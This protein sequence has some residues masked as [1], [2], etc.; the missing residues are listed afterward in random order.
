MQEETCTNNTATDEHT[1]ATSDAEQASGPVT[2]NTTENT[3][4]TP[5]SDSGGLEVNSDTAQSGKDKSG[6]HLV[7]IKSN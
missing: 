2:E 7:S 3:T 6:L 5:V 1:V 4:E